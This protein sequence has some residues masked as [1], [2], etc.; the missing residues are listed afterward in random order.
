[1]FKKF[2]KKIKITLTSKKF[3]KYKKLYVKARAYT[4]DGKAKVY[5]KW[6]KAKK[7]KK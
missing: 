2:T 7:V 1:M 3:K 6:S 4:L 5:G